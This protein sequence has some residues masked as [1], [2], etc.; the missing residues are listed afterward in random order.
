MM[1]LKLWLIHSKIIGAS[2]QH[3]LN[4]LKLFETDK[5]KENNYDHANDIRVEELLPRVMSVVE[6]FDD[7]GKKLF[8][9]V[10]GEISSMG[11]CPQGRI[12]R[13]LEFYLPFRT[14]N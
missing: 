8:L 7:S 9:M 4:T 2:R 11:S 14:L 6:S 13:L 5:N 10:I 12:T 3:I 1:I